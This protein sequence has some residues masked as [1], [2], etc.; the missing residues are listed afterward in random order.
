MSDALGQSEAGSMSASA[1]QFAQI[2]GAATVSKLCQHMDITIDADAEQKGGPCVP[3]K[4]FCKPFSYLIGVFALCRPTKVPFCALCI[5]MCE[6]DFCGWQLGHTLHKEDLDFSSQKNCTFSH[7]QRAFEV[8]LC[9]SYS[10][11]ILP[12]AH[13]CRRLSPSSLEC[14]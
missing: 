8:C 13:A 3:L 14:D 12:T 10:C 9:L 7:Y 5:R 6:A 4:H 1:W 11:K 2:S